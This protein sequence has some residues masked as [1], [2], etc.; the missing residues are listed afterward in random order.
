MFQFQAGAKTVTKVGAACPFHSIDTVVPGEYFQRPPLQVPPYGLWALT[1]PRGPI[2]D[3]STESR[4]YVKTRSPDLRAMG[5]DSEI[6]TSGPSNCLC[7]EFNDPFVFGFTGSRFSEQPRSPATLIPPEDDIVLA[8]QDDP[9][10][11]GGPR[12]SFH[13]GEPHPIFNYTSAPTYV[14]EHDWNKRVCDQ[15]ETSS[16]PGFEYI[17]ATSFMEDYDH[18]RFHTGTAST[19]SGSYVHLTPQ[20]SSTHSYAE[21]D[22]CKVSPSSNSSCTGP[23]PGPSTTGYHSSDASLKSPRHRLLQAPSHVGP[24]GSWI[25]PPIVSHL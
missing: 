17:D 1:S 25:I 8:P 18:N 7:S 13:L 6:P 5:T 24:R 3:L 12:L 22:D 19:T 2:N 11:Y 16:R 14:K 20:A 9:D 23:S 21:T 10:G 4:Y 15:T